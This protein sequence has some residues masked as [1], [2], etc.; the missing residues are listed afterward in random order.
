M[1]MGRPRLGPRLVRK[2]EASGEARRRAEV[3]LETLAGECTL[4]EACEQLDLSE[5]QVLALRDRALEGFASALEQGQPGR[6]RKEEVDSD[7]ELL[8]LKQRCREQAAE[9]REIRLELRAAKVREE[10]AL[11]MPH[12]ARSAETGRLAKKNVGRLAPD[13]GTLQGAHASPR[14]PPAGRGPRRPAPTSARGDPRLRTV[15]APR[16]R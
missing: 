15:P 6:P 11:V 2:V 4:A 3:I 10:I 5:T 16:P 8:S 13:S 7:E 14:A 9:L 1:T 12:L